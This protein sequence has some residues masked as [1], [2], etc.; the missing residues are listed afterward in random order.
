MCYHRLWNST[1]SYTLNTWHAIEIHL[2]LIILILK[3]GKR[4][5]K[6]IFVICNQERFDY[7]LFNRMSFLSFLSHYSWRNH[8]S[9][10]QTIVIQTAQYTN[11]VRCKGQWNRTGNSE[12]ISSINAELIS[13]KSTKKRWWEKSSFCNTQC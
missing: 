1:N 3:T 7:S 4:F 6:H 12:K 5:S 9:C 11:K 8:S 10:F 13:S 2:V